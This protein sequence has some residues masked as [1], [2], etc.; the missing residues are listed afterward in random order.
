MGSAG[1]RAVVD[2][3]IGKR[4][5]GVRLLVEPHTSPLHPPAPTTVLEFDTDAHDLAARVWFDLLGP[6][7]EGVRPTS[8]EDVGA[9]ADR[10]LLDFVAVALSRA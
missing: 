6:P 7:P 4:P 8:D 2:E 3:R 9:W 5:S 1:H 10:V